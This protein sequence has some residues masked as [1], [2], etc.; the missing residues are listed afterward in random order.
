MECFNEAIYNNNS[1]DISSGSSAN[2]TKCKPIT[3]P[4]SDHSFEPLIDS[5]N[6][7]FHL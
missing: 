1:D 4:D 6:E 5:N 3:I 2:S 7:M